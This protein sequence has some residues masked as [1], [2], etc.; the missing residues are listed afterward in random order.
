M[1]RLMGWSIDSTEYSP[2]VVY[3]YP[4]N[5]TLDSNLRAAK[6]QKIDFDWYKRLNI[7]SEISSLLAFLQYEVSPPIV[8]Q[9]LMSCCIFLDEEWCPKICGFD[10]LNCCNNNGN[11]SKSSDVYNLGLVLLELISGARYSG[12]STI[13][14]QKIR[15]GKLEEIVDPCLYY[16]EQ[17]PLRREEI[18]IVADIATRCLLYGGDHG[19]LGIL[20]VSKDLMHLAKESVDGSSRRGPGLEETFSNSSL[21]QMISMS[22]D[23]MYVP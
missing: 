12:F 3:E 9:N 2:L 22:P 1:S 4:S 11:S 14:L 16:H 13:A 6:E 17:P 21:L 8:H 23:S 10:L 5:G 18:E 19:N 7:A 20:D 15:S